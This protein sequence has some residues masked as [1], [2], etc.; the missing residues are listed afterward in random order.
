MIRSYGVEGLQEMLRR[1]IALAAE[2][3]SWVE[4]E[5]GFAVAAPS[6]FGLVCFRH[7]PDALRA[8][9]AAL[10]AWNRELLQRVN[11]DGRVYLTHTVLG[12]RYTLRLAVG[13]WQTEREHVAGAWRLVREAARR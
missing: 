8:D 6:P 11:A 1:H 10:D 3:R 9:P 2:V 5:P 4:A 7:E 12:G 13:Q